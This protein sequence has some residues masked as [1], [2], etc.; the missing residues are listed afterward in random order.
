MYNQNHGVPRTI[1]L[2]QAKFIVGNQVKNFYNKYN[3]DIFDAPVNDHWAIGLVERILLKIDLLV[4]KQT[5]FL[6]NHSTYCRI[7]IL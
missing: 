4:L 7:R 6:Q 5:K 2:Y 3:I 1:R